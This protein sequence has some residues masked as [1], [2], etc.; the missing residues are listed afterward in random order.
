MC[1][2]KTLK[3][4]FTLKSA[5]LKKKKSAGLN[6]YGRFFYIILFYNLLYLSPIEF[7][8]KQ[9]KAHHGNEWS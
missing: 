1:Y 2:P 3:M 5:G 7:L 9:W 6:M 4:I 8:Q